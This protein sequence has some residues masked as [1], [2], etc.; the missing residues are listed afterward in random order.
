[1]LAGRYDIVRGLLVVSPGVNEA[2]QFAHLARYLLIFAAARRALEH[3]VLD[4]VREAVES[5][6]LV[7]VAHLH[8]YQQGDH[9]GAVV[10]LDQHS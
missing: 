1:V 7:K 10:L 2:A 9:R 3:H 8:G 4:E 6:R 5:I